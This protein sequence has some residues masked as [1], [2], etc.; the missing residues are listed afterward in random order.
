MLERCHGKAFG[1]RPCD[2]GKAVFR[3]RTIALAAR[4]V[5]NDTFLQCEA[6]RLIDCQCKSSH[7][8]ELRAHHACLLLNTRHGQNGYPSWLSVEELRLVGDASV[9]NQPGVIS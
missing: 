3:S 5:D 8:R 4:E 7:N 9:A 2:K 1:A 6:L